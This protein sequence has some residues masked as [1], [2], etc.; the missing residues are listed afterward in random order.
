MG[1]V[2]SER[3]A[4]T[5][6]TAHGSPAHLP[7]PLREHLAP[8]QQAAKDQSRRKEDKLSA[9]RLPALR[10]CVLVLV[11]LLVNCLISERGGGPL[12]WALII[13]SPAVSSPSPYSISPSFVP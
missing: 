8:S 4:C 11:C 3:A 2:G 5:Y 1:A 7:I 13:P 12:S 10:W 9:H 6:V